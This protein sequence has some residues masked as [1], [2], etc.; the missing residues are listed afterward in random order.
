CRPTLTAD[1]KKIYFECMQTVGPPH[2]G[3]KGLSDIYYSTRNDTT[4]TWSSPINL[5]DSVNTEYEERRPFISPEGDILLFQ[6]NRDGGDDDIYVSYNINGVWTE[7]VPLEYPVNTSYNDG[8]PALSFDGLRLYFH[9]DRDGDYDIYVAH[10]IGSSWDSVVNIGPPV[11]TTGDEAHPFE[12]PDGTKL[13]FTDWD[14]VVRVGYG[15]LDIWVSTRV[16]DGWGEPVNVGAPVNCDLPA[17]SPFITADGSRFYFGSEAWEGSF[18][19]EDIWYAD[20]IRGTSEKRENVPTSSDWSITGELPGARTV[21]CLIE[22]SDGTIYAGT[23]PNGDVFKRRNGGDGW[24]KVGDLPGAYAVYSLLE[25]S[26]GTIYAGTYPNGDVFKTTDGGSTWTHT[27]DVPGATA[28]RALIQARDGTIY[29]GT[30]P[31]LPENI[32]RVFTSTDGGG[33]WTPAGI[34]PGVWAGLFSLLETEEGSILC[35]GYSRFDCI[36]RSEDAGTTWLP[37]DLPLENNTS[38]IHSLV[39]FSDGTIYAGAYVQHQRG[40]AFKSTDD[41]RTWD[42]TSSVRI[43]P[44]PP[45]RANRVYSVIEGCDG[46]LYI[47]F[48]PGPNRVVSRST[49]GG[50][51]WS[52][53]GAL[54][55]AHE[56]LCLLQASDGW[57]YA[58]TTPEGDV[59]RRRIMERGDV[60]GDGAINVLDVIRTV[61]IILEIEPPATECGR[62]AADCN[63][64][65]G[66]NVLDVVGIVNVIL[67]TGTCNP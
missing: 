15:G 5:G 39:Q 33:S 28:V 32:G 6:S 38:T 4:G 53:F 55:G 30:S 43:P 26:D 27:A 22:G 49:D 14:P 41:G 13:Y 45:L 36:H 29:A 61:N 35:G 25:T 46:G 12:S 31:A 63:G 11:N 52:L 24:I 19:D 2:P 23:Y 50:Q 56:V 58:G 18:G 20:V 16:G 48:Q 9:S 34:V 17:C 37:I 51:T 66:V 8:D 44:T 42:T 62:W 21:Y 60:N 65:G 67:G 40:W 57:I 47:G 3:H 7:A 54:E 10:W 59:F 1:M 64:D